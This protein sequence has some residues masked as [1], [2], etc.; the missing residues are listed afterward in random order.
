[1]N[2]RELSSLRVLHVED[3]D[4]DGQLVALELRRGLG[5]VHVQRVC[6]AAGMRAAL[7]AGSWNAIISDWNMPGFSGAAAFDL[8]QSYGLDVPFIIVSA[9]IG[10]ESAV[11]AMR[12]GAHDYVMKD[13]LARLVPAVQRE[14]R[15]T[16][17]RLERREAQECL[18]VSEARYRRLAESGII[19]IAIADLRG[20]AHEGNDAYYRM[21]GYTQDE[22]FAR[23][24]GWAGQTPAEWKDLDGRAIEQL[25]STGTAA[26][27]EKEVVRKDGSR[28]AVLIGAAMLDDRT[29]IAFAADVT[30]R[31]LAQEALAERARLASLSAE[32]GV[33]LGRAT[34]I[35]QGLQLSADAFVQYGEAEV[36]QLWTCNE[37]SQGLELLVSAGADSVPCTLLEV[38]DIARRGEAQWSNRAA[39]DTEQFLSSA[40]FPLILEDRVLGV[41]AV[42]GHKP[43]REPARQ[44]FASLSA[45][46]AEFIHRKHAEQELIFAKAAAEAASRAKSEFLANISHELRTP[47]NSILG[48]TDLVLFSSLTAE[49]RNLLET[50]KLS[51]ESLLGIIKDILDFSRMEAGRFTLQRAA[52]NV[53]D[54]VSANMRP[55]EDRAAQKGLAMAWEV[56][57]GVP[58]EVLGDPGHLAQILVNL[59]GNAIK[60]TSHGRVAVQV[61]LTSQTVE[62][63]ELEF[64]VSD[65]GVGI[66]AGKQQLIFQAFTQADGSSTRQFEGTGLG[67]TIAARLVEMMNGRIWF[68]SDVGRGSTFHF[69]ARFGTAPP[70]L[71]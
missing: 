67:L 36:A 34:T 48:M 11:S 18:R 40:G 68:E 20:S 45:Q 7:D 59:A 12:A 46:L 31:K 70:P 60:F 57:S 44:T 30:D 21:V 43:F 28:V 33:V 5:E 32:V 6:D 37:T 64:T 1:L 53:R 38:E 63:T 17:L 66:P 71:K 15:E 56:D 16:T 54:T 22:L 9:A 13:N 42:F 4:E 52:L 58:A 8:V 49:Q 69:T 23:D 65:T 14:L 35:R 29:C 39:G 41:A 3:S 25:H 51:S 2:S 19:G 61:H 10:E 47:L 24:I 27:W 62:V 50:V 26:P 55:L